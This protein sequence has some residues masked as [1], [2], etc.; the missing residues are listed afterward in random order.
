[1]QFSLIQKIILWIVPL[2]FAITLHEAAH[3]WVANKLGD[4]TAKQLGR[5]TLN[6]V[7][8]IDLVGTVI[9]P[10]ILL[11]IGGVV[12]GYAKPV[13]INWRNLRQPRRDMVLVALAGPMAN[14]LMAI[15]WAAIAKLAVWQYELGHLEISGP[16][17]FMS[18]T[19]IMLNLVLLVLN[20]LPIPPLD[21]SRV[22]ASLLHG[23]IAYYYARLESFGFLILLVLLLLGILSH[24]LN[25]I[26]SALSS[27]LNNL[28][29]LPG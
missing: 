2:V 8:H 15:I 20:L 27:I 21:G 5:L 22:T 19:G 10:T 4:P 12:F 7:K 16:L 3:G 18:M 29:N 13:P 17:Y 24:I 1:M 9:I 25:P 28:F 11:I 6:P 14:A 23:K 26:V